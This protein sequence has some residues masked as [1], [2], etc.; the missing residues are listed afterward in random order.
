MTRT[1]IHHQLGGGINDIMTMLA[2][3]TISSTASAEIDEFAARLRETFLSL[4]VLVLREHL[5]SPAGTF[6]TTWRIQYCWAFVECY[7]YFLH[8]VHS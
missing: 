3:M 6:R 1:M 7:H 4:Q 2:S 8:L 5:L